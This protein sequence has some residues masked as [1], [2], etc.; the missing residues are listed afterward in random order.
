MSTKRHP[1]ATKR[2]KSLRES[3][4]DAEQRL[5]QALRRRQF[6]GHKFRRQH[7]IGIYIVDFACLEQWLVIEVDGGHHLEQREYDAAREHWIA[8][9]GF[10]VLRFWDS[11]VLTALDSVAT[12]ILQALAADPL[13]NPPPPAGEGTGGKLAV[14]GMG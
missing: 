5:W 1:G 7:P 9:Q 8:G 11:D 14:P 2:A 3:P 12:V 13:P 6:E 4:T 10:R